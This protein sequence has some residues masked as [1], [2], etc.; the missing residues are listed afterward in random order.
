M[1]KTIHRSLET[2]SLT[3]FITSK[4]SKAIP[5]DESRRELNLLCRVKYLRSLFDIVC[6]ALVPFDVFSQQLLN[7][8]I[9]F[10]SRFWN[11]MPQTFDI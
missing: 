4:S 11:T 1:A 2:E 3:T 9:N 7:M 6:L 8:N 5:H 10:F